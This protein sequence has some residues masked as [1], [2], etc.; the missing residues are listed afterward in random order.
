MAT[1]ILQGTKLTVSVL[2]LKTF[3]KGYWARTKI[4]VENE[5]VS[6]YEEGENFTREEMEEWIFCMYRLLAGA[7]GKE[8]SLSFEKA[9]VACDFYSHTDMG[10]EVSRKQR[11]EH[12]CVMALRLLMRSSDKKRLYGGVYSFLLHREEIQALADGLRKEF[13]A[14]FCRHI[15]GFGE[16]TFVGVSPYGCRGCNYWYLDPTGK[17]KAGDYV[18][19]RMGRRDTE[20]VVYVD[21]VRQYS[22]ET[23]PY[24]PERVKRVL[25]VATQEEIPQE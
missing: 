12:D 16:Y 24:P 4:C 20:Q 25:R 11:R 3:S 1:V 8:Y 10:K 23:A 2:P 15:K 22:Q 7:Y 17:T 6:Y 19:V 21:S 14:A 9:G 18:W 5:Y 13:D